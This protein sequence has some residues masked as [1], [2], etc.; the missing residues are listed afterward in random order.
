MQD[1]NARK[2][3]RGKGPPHTYKEQKINMNTGKEK[4]SVKG[5]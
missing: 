5:G 1:K 3:K 2:R 4:V